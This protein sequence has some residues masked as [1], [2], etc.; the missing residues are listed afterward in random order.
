MQGSRPGLTPVNSNQRGRN[1]SFNDGVKGSSPPSPSSS[2]PRTPAQQ[3]PSYDVTPWAFQ[4][5]QVSSCDGCGQGRHCQAE[6]LTRAFCYRMLPT[7]PCLLIRLTAAGAP[8]APHIHVC[9]YPDIDTTEAMRRSTATSKD[10]LHAL[11]RAE[12]ILSACV[13]APPWHK[14]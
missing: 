5:S 11:R 3:G 2:R 13:K 7:R 6:M 12:S 10:L 1:N 4:D 9:T 14:R 8:K